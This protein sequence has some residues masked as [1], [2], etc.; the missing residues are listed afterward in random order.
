MRALLLLYRLN[1][2]AQV[3]R[4]WSGMKTV[5]G[6]FLTLMMLF[7]MSMIIIPNLVVHIAL[8]KPPS[9]DKSTFIPFG[10]FV[11][12]LVSLL[13][14]IG[15]QAIYFTPSEVDN[16]FCA[17]F[18]RRQLLGYKIIAWVAAAF[19][20]GLIFTGAFAQHLHSLIFGFVG[21]SL[22]FLFLT[23]ASM[24]VTL[25][26]QILSEKLFSVGRQVVALICLGAFAIAM[27]QAITQ[28]EFENLK[29]FTVWLQQISG[30]TMG[31]IV[32]MPFRIF[33]DAIFAKDLLSFLR[34]VALATMMNVGLVIVILMLDA[35]YLETAANVSRK[36]FEKKE[37]MKT[38]KVKISAK[39]TRWKL[40]MFPY[41]GGFGPMAWRQLVSVIRPSKSVFI[42]AAVIS[43]CASIPVLMD[44]KSELIE[45]PAVVAVAFGAMAY[46]TAIFSLSLPYGFRA[47]IDHI[48]VFKSLPVRPFA[49]AAGEIVGSVALFASIH[50]FMSIVGLIATRNFFLW[51]VAGMIF[52]LPFNVLVCSLCNT[53]FLLFPMRNFAGSKDIQT[54]SLGFVFMLFQAIV[55]LG[56]AFVCV[57]PALLVYWLSSN[58]FLTWS[59]A[60]VLLVISATVSVYFTGRTYENFDVTRI[61]A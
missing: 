40:K 55:F 49:I 13:T 30:S 21:I 12:F 17:P 48:E 14:S 29:D 50:L 26:R 39:S 15:D 24:L 19:L 27:S 28:I 56:V 11:Y 35:N 10:L 9:I 2:K 38:G 43:I 1:I 36:I 32:L 20:M 54:L 51:W 16:L 7:L 57:V 47:D 8:D 41:Y 53:L 6:A 59:T 46:L 60:W 18:T 34:W 23:L 22:T 4:L 44:I 45:T 52:I 33:S 3:R 42:V 58:Q 31:Q 25:V 5:K 37:R 61:P